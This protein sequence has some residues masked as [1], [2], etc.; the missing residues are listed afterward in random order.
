M[1]F[2]QL[3]DKE[4][5]MKNTSRRS[6]GRSL[7]SALA[8]IPV[9][10]LASKSTVKAQTDKGSRTRMAKIISHENTP[11]PITVEDG[12]FH[13]LIRRPDSAQPILTQSGSGKNWSYEG[14]INN[15]RNSIAHIKILH[16][17]GEWVY[18]DLNAAGSRILIELTNEDRVLVG[19]LDIQGSPGL[20]KL[21]STGY[22]NGNGN[23]KLDHA[24]AAGK[25]HYKHKWMHKGGDA[26]REFRITRIQVIKN[27][28]LTLDEQVD[29]D[30]FLS[31]EYRIL[32]WLD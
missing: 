19:T 11:P 12:S 27:S 17:T 15:S 10:A 26:A 25:P 13:M 30:E 23:G 7:A 5:I 28:V 4:R 32:I 31:Q 16:G 2:F 20:F 18:R 8:A 21:N 9:A 14:N 24:K 3:D 29:L 1:E 6:F 22:G